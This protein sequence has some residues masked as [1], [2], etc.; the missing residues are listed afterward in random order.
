MFTPSCWQG[1]SSVVMGNCGFT[2]APV[3][4][5]LED[6]VVQDLERA[7]D[8][9][10]E[11]M[12]AGIKWHW[13]TYPEYLDKLEALPKALN[14]AVNIGH[15]AVRTYVMGERA[16]SDTA[17]AAEVGQMRD[18][19]REALRVGAIGFTT[20]RIR[21]H[22]RTDNR[23]ID[24]R[25]ADWAEL[26]GIVSVL[27]E[28]GQGIFEVATEDA[29]RVP[30]EE[31]R[32]AFRRYAELSARHG[33]PV[34]MGMPVISEDDERSVLDQLKILDEVNADGGRFLVLS[35]SKGFNIMLSFETQTP[36]DHLPVWREL[37]SR[38]LPEQAEML[39]DP[40][41]RARLIEAADAAKEEDILGASA[42]TA[43]FD[44]I[45][46]YDREEW[47]LRTVAE[48]ARAR[49]QHPV[50]VMI[51]IALDRDLKLW[52]VQFLYKDTELLLDVLK[53]PM[54][55]CTFGDAGAHVGQVADFNMAVQF[56][57]YWVKERKAFTLEKGVQMITEA[58]ARA[59]GFH[60]RGVLREGLAADINVI[61]FARLQSKLPELVRDLPGGRTAHHPACGG[62]PGHSGKRR[63]HPAGWRRH[64]RAPGAPGVRGT[65]HGDGLRWRRGGRPVR[66]DRFS[67]PAGTTGAGE[68]RSLRR[69]DERGH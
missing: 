49:N 65:G 24:S 42:R 30:G 34:A 60:D 3:H 14:C 44:L 26:E 50:E 56:L 12:E 40:A 2:L 1:V 35:H 33:V 54:S 66:C 62:H 31:G 9:P 41:L 68:R 46:V 17:T 8:I 27:G 22:V 57:S 43:D 39:R 10:D 48:L 52:F 20:T 7:K 47:P 13:E 19:V 28:E 67:V 4:K 59:W 58:P 23:P 18:L 32:A 36:F 37:R 5:G 53:H 45:R 69:P 61:D 55:L 63:D 16:L 11:A 38:P 15:S 64:R 51:D 29:T 6:M 25:L 21:H